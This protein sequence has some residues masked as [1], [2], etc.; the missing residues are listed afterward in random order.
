MSKSYP[1]PYRDGDEIVEGYH[2]L[3]WLGRGGF[4]EVWE[5]TA[6]GAVPVAIKIISLEKKE[7][8]KEF[9]AIKRFRKIS[10]P[11]LVS[12]RALWLRDS[13]GN[14]FSSESTDDDSVNLKGHATELIIAMDLCEKS[15]TDRLK[16]SPGGIPRRELLRYM[17]GAAQAIDFLNH[18]PTETRKSIQHCDIKP[19]NILI[20]GGGVKVCDFGLARVLEDTARATQTEG[21]LSLAYTSPELLDDHSKPSPTSDQYSLAVSY[22]ELRTG[23]LPFRQPNNYVALVHDITQG[24]LD[25]SGLNEV[26]QLVIR[27]AAA[28][29]PARRYPRA[30][31]FVKALSRAKT[32][33]PLNKGTPRPSAPPPSVVPPAVEPFRLDAGRE[34]VPD[35]RLV[36][37]LG[38]GGY[39]EVWEASAPGGLPTALKI[40]RNLEGAGRQ[41]FKAL[42]LIKGL[43][44]NHLLE[45]RAYWV[46]DGAG[47][48]IPDHVRGRPDTPNP[49]ILV[50]ATRLAQQ[51]LL[52]RLH[53]CQEARGGG[54]IP[55]AELIRYMR[56]AAVAIDYLNEPRDLDGD[57]VSI[58]HRDI[59]PENLL[60]LRDGTVK[61]GD[62]GLARVLKGTAAAIPQR[63]V[64]Y[65]PSYAAPEMFRHKVTS[66]SDQYALALTYYHL[67]TGSLPFLGVGSAEE[68]AVLKA[69]GGLDLSRLPQGEAD[70]VARATS[71]SPEERYPSCLTM[72]AALDAALRAPGMTAT[73]PT[74]PP[75]VT[76]DLP[77]PFLPAVDVRNEPLPPPAAYPPAVLTPRQA[78]ATPH[79]H[80][81]TAAVKAIVKAAQEEYVLFPTVAGPAIGPE[82]PTQAGGISEGTGGEAS[83]TTAR[84]AAPAEKVRCAWNQSPTRRRA[85][86]SSSPLIA[87]A[88]VATACLGGCLVWWL[89]KG[90][91]GT[92]EMSSA[93]PVPHEGRNGK[94]EKP[95]DTAPPVPGNRANPSPTHGPPATKVQTT[96]EIGARVA[97]KLQDGN[98]CLAGDEP[99]RLT[100]A[101]HCFSEALA[102]IRGAEEPVLERPFD[103]LWNDAVLGLARVCGRET[104]WQQL[105]STL[106]DMRPHD[107]QQDKIARHDF[108]ARL[109]AWHGPDQQQP[110]RDD[111]ALLKR[112]RGL[113]VLGCFD[114][115]EARQYQ[116]LRKETIARVF[117]A[118]NADPG[119]D[120]SSLR[121][122][123]AA[124]EQW[125]EV[126]NFDAEYEADV[127]KR[128]DEVLAELW[129]KGKACRSDPR[130]V[131]EAY[132]TDQQK[133]AAKEWLDKAARLA[134]RA[135]QPL[136][137][138]NQRELALALWHGS[139]DKEPV[140]ER[141]AELIKGYKPELT[142]QEIPYILVTAQSQPDT[143]EGLAA[144]FEAYFTVFEFAE[145]AK[146]GKPADWYHKALSPA[147]SVGVRLAAWEPDADRA[148][149]VA[150]RER[151]G[152]TLFLKAK[153]LDKFQNDLTREWERER[154]VA[155]EAATKYREDP[156]TLLEV[157]EWHRTW[158]LSYGES[159]AL[160][161][162]Y[163]LKAIADAAR[164]ADSQDLSL[165]ARAWNLRGL[166]FED[167]AA[168]PDQ[169][170]KNADAIEAH[171]KAIELDPS[172]KRYLLDRGRCS[173]HRTAHLVEPGALAQA[174]ESARSDLAGALRFAV[175][176]AEDEP[177]DG[178]LP[179][180]KRIEALYWLGMTCW[181][182]R[183]FA[184][185]GKQ[186]A[187]ALEE[188]HGDERPAFFFDA[189]SALLNLGDALFTES[190]E[191]LGGKDGGVKRI[192][193]TDMHA[194]A[195]VCFREFSKH[196]HKLRKEE[197]HAVKSRS[198]P[199]PASAD[200]TFLE[201]VANGR[202]R[203]LA[204][205]YLRNDKNQNPDRA[206]EIL[207]LGLPE[208]LRPSHVFCL[209]RRNFLYGSDMVGPQMGRLK[210]ENRR[211]LNEVIK[212]AETAVEL[213]RRD[214][215]LIEAPYRKEAHFAAYTVYRR[216][217]VLN[218]KKTDKEKANEHLRAVLKLCS[219]PDE[220]AKTEKLLID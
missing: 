81:G 106:K 175:A 79:T 143:Q 160:R 89:S 27:R 1:R 59:K 216:A 71:K 171:A 13:S 187:Q 40:I 52:Q 100:E 68:L 94:Y 215:V 165:R 183:D 159:S 196:A 113:E 181:Q 116:G 218:N 191:F 205:G 157:Y 91:N 21:H 97:A 168:M 98:S 135:Q 58:Q 104:N 198:F 38:G 110:R 207:N 185:A 131:F 125:D 7:G 120:P 9:R 134:G 133:K 19:H 200:S 87:F 170:E 107:G 80:G 57:V 161:K 6:P 213:A 16:E 99:N 73:T 41:E 86:R 50:I 149:G 130:Q 54:G 172:Q 35:H 72:V 108:L 61:V 74:P 148:G 190:N 194:V 64:G 85:L 42:E 204:E 34:I 63:S 37:Y 144:A 212:D 166:A 76:D 78:C 103:H 150:F 3:R 210:P 146:V 46:L 82:T 29:D 32:G 118:V 128:K 2:L 195:V 14:L 88:L 11:N 70:V 45:L 129:K 203:L 132:D 174:R 217:Y 109:A 177:G 158:A 189:I 182:Q 167:L 154:M 176:D 111:F 62:F 139:V 179:R 93:T 4:G 186:L 208:D 141:V 199:V 153:L 48:V 197:V 155:G 25:L 147:V 66:R 92:S 164:A 43:E 163:L 206:I 124:F 69:E 123:D 67:R 219:D 169:K 142:A 47:R 49:S 121:H 173:Y 137:A 214:P 44:H 53:Q 151:L 17:E 115:W 20:V 12:V 117:E 84:E 8:F 201:A 102:E 60:L 112:L 119:T 33:P 24:K 10:H 95:T 105:L 26:E 178:R 28:V 22:V 96:A 140:R 202:L 39:G 220:I 156:G 188:S 51:N 75:I 152:R 193:D 77:R 90:W 31:R 127:A 122:L 138:E 23:R 114:P 192:R 145:K 211:A 55:P 36:R 136:K 18:P 184:E 30:E 126:V 101:R 15:L 162:E 65:T 209:S 5:A 83:G 180:G 56:E